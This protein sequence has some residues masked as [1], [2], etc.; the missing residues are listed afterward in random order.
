[1]NAHSIPND[2]GRIIRV[3]GADP[4]AG[5]DATDNNDTNGRWL[6]MAYRITLVADATVTNRRVGFAIETGGVDIFIIYATIDQTAGQTITYNFVAGVPDRA[7]AINSNLQIGI[8]LNLIVGGGMAIKTTTVNLQA[9]D[10]FAAPSI[11][12]QFWV[13]D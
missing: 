13:E 3:N 2:Q 12:Y 8:P 10:N 6:I 4:A 1:M 5:A 7:A 9:G 11:Y